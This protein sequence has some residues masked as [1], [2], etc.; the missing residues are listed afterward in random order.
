MLQHLETAD[1][2]ERAVGEGQVD[3]A[4]GDESRLPIRVGGDLKRRG[5]D[6][7]TRQTD[8]RS[9][10]DDP[11]GDKALAAAGVEERLRRECQNLRDD[12]AMKSVDERSL[13]RIRRGVLAVVA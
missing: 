13:Q 8:T 12:L 1:D 3:D 2:V 6:I 10:V 4:S 5:G 9:R 11:A 7:A